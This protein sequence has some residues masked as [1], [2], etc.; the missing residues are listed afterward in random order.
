[1]A[2]PAETEVAFF[3][4]R[5]F[6]ELK[7]GFDGR[8]SGPPRPRT[9]VQRSRGSRVTAVCGA[10][11]VSDVFHGSPFAEDNAVWVLGLIT[12]VGADRTSGLR[13]QLRPISS[14]LSP[15]MN[16]SLQDHSGPS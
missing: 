13:L 9:T 12:S 7:N 16:R 8:A 11:T 2:T 6:L 10:E 3:C 5:R 4:R 14:D 1:V 15:G